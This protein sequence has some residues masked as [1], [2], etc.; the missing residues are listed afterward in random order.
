MKNYRICF[1][2]AAEQPRKAIIYLVGIIED[3]EARNRPLDWLVTD[4]DTGEEHKIRCTLAEL[5]AEAKADL[6]KFLKK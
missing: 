6:D 3:P 2:F 1:D 4:Q 5:E